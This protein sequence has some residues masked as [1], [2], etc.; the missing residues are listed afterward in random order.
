MIY[1]EL[2]NSIVEFLKSLNNTQNILWY[3]TKYY[4]YSK[5]DRYIEIKVSSG[6]RWQYHFN[7][8]ELLRFSDIGNDDWTKYYNIFLDEKKMENRNEIINEIL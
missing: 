8:N 3:T 1:E 4:E 6:T 5:Y 7:E 2:I